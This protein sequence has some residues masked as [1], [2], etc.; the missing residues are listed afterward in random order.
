MPARSA[1]PEITVCWRLRTS[2]RAESLLGRVARHVAAAEG[3]AR[4]QLSVVVV[5]E[6]AMS[7]L[8]ARYGHNPESTDVLAFDLGTD[9][10]RGLLDGEIVIC[11]AV[12]RQRCR[13]QLGP[14]ARDL[15][16]HARAELALYLTHG[17]LH[18]AGYDDHAPRAYRRMH[19][20]ED[21]LLTELGLGPVFAAAAAPA[22]VR[23]SRSRRPVGA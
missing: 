17:L 1:G 2:W 20:R 4:G 9:R 21:E 11:A 8:H 19:A 5:A 6:R 16:K 15:L 14:G 22:A 3:F 10:R 12:A 23:T 7:T 18:L 13:A